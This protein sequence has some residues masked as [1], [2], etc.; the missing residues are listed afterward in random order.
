MV[1][2]WVVTELAGF[3][4]VGPARYMPRRKLLQTAKVHW[5]RYAV[6]KQLS[7]GDDR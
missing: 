2:D 1:R 5:C 3:Q 4:R 6:T 7:S